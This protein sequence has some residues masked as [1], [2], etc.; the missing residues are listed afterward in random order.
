MKKPHKKTLQT[1]ITMFIISV[2]IVTVYYFVRTDRGIGVKNTQSKKTQAEILVEQDIED[3][4]PATPKDVLELYI[5]I[6][7]YCYDRNTSEEQIDK[8]AAQARLLYDEEL[9][10]N[11][12]LEI[13]KSNLQDEINRFRDENIDVMNYYTGNDEDAEF[14][15]NDNKEY[16]SRI[17]TYT[18]KDG[19]DYTK[20]YCTFILRRDNN[21]KWKILGWT[22]DA[23]SDIK[24]TTEE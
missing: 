10:E 17:V 5:N 22:N 19:S 23:A 18:L 3:E 16:A 20:V 11:N 2:L 12:P 14:W 9:L 1:I 13:Y 24:G 21:S 7:K 6:S 15:T 8:L 4:Y